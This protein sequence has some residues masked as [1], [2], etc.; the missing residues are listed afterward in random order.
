MPLAI[1]RLIAKAGVCA[2]A[3]SSRIPAAKGPATQISE[4]AE[5]LPALSL[6]I[7]APA[8]GVRQR[9]PLRT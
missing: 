5:A 4:S 8:V 3:D 2:S 7:P 9:P 6:V 1:F